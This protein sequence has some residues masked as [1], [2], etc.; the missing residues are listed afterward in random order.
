MQVIVYTCMYVCAI[1]H[2]IIVDSEINYIKN[3]ASNHDLGYRMFS[4]AIAR[5]MDFG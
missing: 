5:E 2:K 1:V 3:I 4:S